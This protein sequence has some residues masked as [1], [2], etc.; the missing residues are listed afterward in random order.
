[1]NY[2]S[3]RYLHAKTTVD[4]RA[5]SRVVYED[6]KREIGVK[7]LDVLELGAGVGTM[8]SRA[9]EWGL[10]AQG[11]WTL[12]DEDARSIGEA[13]RGLSAWCARQHLPC[14]DSAQ[15]LTI[16]GRL[17]VRFI[18]SS[19]DTWL[20]NAAERKWSLLIANAFL[21]LIDL[22]TVLPRLSKLLRPD[23]RFWFT[24][25]FDGES[26]F[27]PPH[28][29]DGEVLAVYHRSMDTRVRSGKP[30]G[31]SRT[32]R[33]LFQQ[34]PAAGLEITAAGSSDWVVHS[35][36]GRYIGDEAYF[37]EHIIAT[38]EAELRARPSEISTRTVERWVA[39]RRAQL[40]VA[41]LSYIAHQLDFT[42]AL[43]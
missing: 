5:L 2:D 17:E 19:L 16:D 6:L 40:S 28:H 4:D 43:T 11:T 1:M 22:K 31:S 39:E 21:D 34:L 32:G 14:A 36:A 41:S 25:N 38:V 37:L 35:R 10:V 15:G 13:V 18:H 8:V 20:D 29:D 24:I 3:V 42:G 23:G 27:C 33:E 26:I 30:A 9:L 12:L 7:P